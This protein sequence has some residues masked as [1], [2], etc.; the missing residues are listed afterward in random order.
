MKL[1][2]I[3]SLDDLISLVYPE[4]CLCCEGPL[5][6]GEDAIC[7]RC[8]ID[9]P[10]T[11][12]HADAC[13]PMAAKFI[14]RLNLDHALAFLR[15]RK[16]GNVQRLLHALKYQG[17]REIGI[18]L[19]RVYGHQLCKSIATSHYDVIT[20]VPLHIS[21]LRQRGYNQSDE[22]G[23]G[24]SQATGIPFESNVL[25]RGHKTETQTKK[26]KLNRWRNVEKIFYVKNHDLIV[27]KK[28]LLVDDVVTTGATL[29]SCAVALLNA[30]CKSVGLACIAFAE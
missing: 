26:T 17:H 28:V 24:I 21:R 9:L 1:N 25:V 30:G 14:G 7:T 5:V 20:S 10:R 27:G 18:K 15:F 16:K 29:E 22:W 2:F 19:G 3:E 6:K 4:V 11:N 12:Y 13:N 8:I 23:R